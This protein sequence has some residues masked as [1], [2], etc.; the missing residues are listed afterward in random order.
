LNSLPTSLRRT[1]TELSE[2]GEFKRLQK[3]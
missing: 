3:T 2:L 1:D